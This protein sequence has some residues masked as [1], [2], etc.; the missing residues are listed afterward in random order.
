M[1]R[2]YLSLLNG[3]LFSL[4]ERLQRTTATE[5][6]EVEVGFDEPRQL[7]DDDLNWSPLSVQDMKYAVSL[8]FN[9][10]PTLPFT[11]RLFFNLGNITVIC[12]T[13]KDNF[14]A[15]SRPII[16]Q[17]FLLN[18]DLVR[19]PLS[20]DYTNPTGLK[21]DNPLWKDEHLGFGH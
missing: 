10:N 20:P 12:A 3:K 2:I 18:D 19:I 7:L 17:I 11:S 16:T 14:L 9:T 1:I 5:K 6:R 21:F 4:F 15:E 8:F 13:N